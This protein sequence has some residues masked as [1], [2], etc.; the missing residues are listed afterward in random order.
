VRLVEGSASGLGGYDYFR[1]EPFGLPI[2]EVLPRSMRCSELYE[3][4]ERRLE[5]YF[6]APVQALVQHHLRMK[7]SAS[8]LQLLAEA[9]PSQPSTPLAAPSSG[10]SGS[11]DMPEDAYDAAFQAGRAAAERLSSISS[12]ATDEVFAGGI[13]KRGFTL[14][15]VNGG[16]AAGIS[17]SK[18]SWLR[19][20]QGCVL[21]DRSDVWHGLQ[22]G[23]SIAVDWHVIVFE[24]LLDTQLATFIGTHASISHE[25]SYLQDAKL[26]L[27]QCLDKFTESESLEDVACP[28]CARDR[29]M[30]KSFQLWRLPPVLVVQLKRFQFDRTSRKKLNQCVDFPFRDLDVA[31]YIAASK[32]QALDERGQAAECSKYDLYSVIH[33]IG[34]LGGGHYVATNKHSLRQKKAK[35][36]A[37]TGKKTLSEGSE[38][39]VGSSS[40]ASDSAELCQDECKWY[41]YNDNLVTEVTDLADIT[42]PSAYVLFYLRKDMELMDLQHVLHAIQIPDHAKEEEGV[43]S[44]AEQSGDHQQQQQLQHLANG[45]SSLPA[46]ASSSGQGVSDSPATPQR[47]MQRSAP[48]TMMNAVRSKGLPKTHPTSAS[49]GTSILPAATPPSPRALGGEEENEG[50]NEGSCSIQ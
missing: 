19:R 16:A 11:T 5:V 4:M 47:R 43:V 1:P 6:K 22:D 35:P 33:H 15:L 26:P 34:A 41:C 20:C 38:H 2:L 23:E 29:S 48:L 17:C 40:D 44:P 31:D 24:D 8:K 32:R 39:T 13:P 37:A 50:N 9:K 10:S 28:K 14:R 25:R 18:C 49:T 7:K 45:H 27:A 30:K 42:A 12:V 46:A 21:P 36:A 3:R